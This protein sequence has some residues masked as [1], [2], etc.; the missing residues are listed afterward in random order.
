MY[1]PVCRWTAPPSLELPTSMHSR[2]RSINYLGTALMGSLQDILA[3]FHT[4]VSFVS[5]FNSIVRRKVSLVYRRC[6]KALICCCHVPA[7][8]GCHVIHPRGRAICGLVWQIEQQQLLIC[9]HLGKLLILPLTTGRYIVYTGRSHFGPLR[10]HLET[11]GGES[12]IVFVSCSTMFR[13]SPPLT[14]LAPR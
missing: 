8:L 13:F 3:V 14:P 12:T 2:S 4:C 10:L 11:F 1:C 9:P 6:Y 5:G 7:V